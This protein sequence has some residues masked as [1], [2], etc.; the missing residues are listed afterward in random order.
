MNESEG[1]PEDPLIAAEKFLHKINTD[2][3]FRKKFS[4]APITAIKEMFPDLKDVPNEEFLEA[5]SEFQK[6]SI[7]EFEARGPPKSET[8]MVVA[9]ARIAAAVATAGAK[10]HFIQNVAASV[11]A[12][13]AFAA[14]SAYYKK[15]T[16]REVD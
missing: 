15:Y 6:N 11:V 9:A 13:A 16:E 3:E 10:T 2:S 7:Q 14:A 4:N 1:K 5:Y 8:D 12:N